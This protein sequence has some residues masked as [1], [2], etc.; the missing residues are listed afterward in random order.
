VNPTLTLYGLVLNTSRPVFSDAA[1]RRAVNY[2]VDRRTLLSLTA[3]FLPATVT[4]QYL[5][6][7][8]PGFR[9]AR[10][11]PD[12]PD[13]GR[14]R[15]LVGARRMTA[16]MYSCTFCF[17]VTNV[18]V[19]D[20]AAIGID[21]R[22]KEFAVA[23]LDRRIG[24]RGEPFDLA[25]TARSADYGDPSALLEPLFDGRTIRAADNANRSYL[26][27]SNV[28]R[29]LDAADRLSGPARY[30]AYAELDHYLARDVAPLVAV[31]NATR[32][33][34]FS[35]RIGCNVYQP[36]YGIDL[37]GLCIRG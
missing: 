9:D 11:Y 22:V 26:N 32:Q 19:R 7:G 6:P 4:D 27:D 25:I 1:L 12:R 31:A 2:A 36:I 3:G 17:P 28:I 23:A 33:D 35:S 15:R 24:T 30:L 29:R 10:V 14:A 13:M 5:P 16:V 20:L 37:A 18:V 8:M 21:V 34:F